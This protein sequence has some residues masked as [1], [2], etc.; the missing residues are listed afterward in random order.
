MRHFWE[1]FS[2]PFRSN[3]LIFR[4]KWESVVFRDFHEKRVG[5]FPTGAA[6]P[7]FFYKK[8]AFFHFF[9]NLGQKTRKT[10]FF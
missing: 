2:L 7:I 6:A 5:F 3:F 9:E 1:G 10:V 4:Q 8:H